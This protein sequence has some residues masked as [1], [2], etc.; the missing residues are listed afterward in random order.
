MKLA[1]G[2]AKN[3]ASFSISAQTGASPY[4]PIL[5]MFW[6]ARFLVEVRPNRIPVP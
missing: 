1:E 6:K 4:Q 3:T 2:F 5:C